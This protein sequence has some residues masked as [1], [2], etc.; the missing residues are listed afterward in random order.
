[1][2]ISMTA[3]E[4]LAELTNLKKVTHNLFAKGEWMK[5]NGFELEFE[6]GCTCP[7][8]EFWAIR[9]DEYWQTGWSIFKENS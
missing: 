1:M 8:H 4:I 3:N 5:L 6:D 9:Q 7:L 2:K